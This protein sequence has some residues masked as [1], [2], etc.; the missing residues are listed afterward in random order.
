[1]L[2]PSEE[3]NEKDLAGVD[4]WFW[5]ESGSKAAQAANCFSLNKILKR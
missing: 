3:L 1:M 5:N 2:R 4:R